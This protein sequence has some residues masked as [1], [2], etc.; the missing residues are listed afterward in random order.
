MAFATTPTKQPTP[1]RI[2][3]I[4]SIFPRRSK[5][6]K[7]SI[8]YGCN[9]YDN[10]IKRIKQ[11]IALD[12]H[13]SC[14]TDQENRCED[15]KVDTE[16][17]ADGFHYSLFFCMIRIKGIRLEKDKTITVVNRNLFRDH[18]ET[19]KNWTCHPDE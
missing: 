1:A 8:P 13:Q 16:S 5:R 14:Y 10:K 12:D 9:R 19:K 7:V 17:Q 15:C 6:V 3:P 11:G 18:D 2:I 4:T